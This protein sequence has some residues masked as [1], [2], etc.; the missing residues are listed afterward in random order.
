M[1]TI[2][3]NNCVYKM[4]PIFNLHAGSKDGKIIHIIKQVPHKGKKNNVGYM[5]INVR[6]H[7]QSGFKN[8]QIHR[9]IWECWRGVIADGKEIDHIDNNKENNHLSNLQLL[10]HS[11]NCKKAVKHRKTFNS[12][13]NRKCVKATNKNTNEIFYYWSMYSVEQHLKINRADISKVCEGITKSALSKRDGHWYTFEYFKEEDL[14]QNYIK[15][16]NIRTRKV[17]DEDKKKT[18][19]GVVESRIQMS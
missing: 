8:Y 5:R 9:F 7:G 10:T 15:S 19:T 14:P 17:S 11:E 6:K 2:T 18:S 12:H 13:Q 4:H 3:I 1:T 16:K